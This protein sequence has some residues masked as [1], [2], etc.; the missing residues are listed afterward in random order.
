MRGVPG[1]GKS[2]WVANNVYPAIV[3]SADHYHAGGGG[4]YIYRPENVGKAHAACLKK[5]CNYLNLAGRTQNMVVD[6]TN[7]MMWEMA[8]YVSLAMAFDHEFRIVDIAADCEEAAGRNIHGVPTEVVKSM[9]FRNTSESYPYP[10]K[11]NVMFV[12]DI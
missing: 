10:W 12:K 3:C 8:P 4:K 5:Y 9:W 11:D 1:S 7:T 6:N 2:T